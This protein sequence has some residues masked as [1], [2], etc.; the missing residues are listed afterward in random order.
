MKRE[1]E[2]LM[3][4]RPEYVKCILR[5]YIKDGTKRS[6][7]DRQI[8]FGEWTLGGLDHAAYLGSSRLLLCSECVAA[9][10]AALNALAWHEGP[11]HHASPAG[12]PTEQEC[13]LYRQDGKLMARTKDGTVAQLAVREEIPDGTITGGDAARARGKW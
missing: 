6:W 1:G 3:V 7:C 9:A 12:N 13:F 10:T 8:E 11:D 2:Q 5:A 4:E